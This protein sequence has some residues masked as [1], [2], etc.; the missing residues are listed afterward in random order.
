MIFKWRKRCTALKVERECR[1]G[2]H[3]SPRRCSRERNPIG[4][5]GV[6]DN[7]TSPQ[8]RECAFTEISTRG[9]FYAFSM[10]T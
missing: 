9:D 4:C 8:N 5:D 6:E 10:C 3:L 1:R 7:K 2:S